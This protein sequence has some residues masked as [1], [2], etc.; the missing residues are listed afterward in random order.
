VV[1]P[2]EGCESL[3]RALNAIAAARGRDELR[4]AATPF[5]WG[6]AAVFEAHTDNWRSVFDYLVDVLDYVD[7]DLAYVRVLPERGSLV[8]AV[9][10]LTESA[11][12]ELAAELEKRF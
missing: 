5:Y 9:V 2:S 11:A 8:F 4:V 10:P 6:E 1:A 7:P 12:D 3:A